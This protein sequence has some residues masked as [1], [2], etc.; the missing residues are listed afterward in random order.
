MCVVCVCKSGCMC[1]VYVC[2][3]VLPCVC[4]HVCA[5]CGEWVPLL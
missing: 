1:G 2:G 4:V 3:G 5:I